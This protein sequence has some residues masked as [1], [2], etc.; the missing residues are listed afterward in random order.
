MTLSHEPTTLVVRPKYL[1]G[2]WDG[3]LGPL[4]PPPATMSSISIQMVGG[5]YV[6]VG[7]EQDEDDEW[8]VDRAVFRWEVR[9]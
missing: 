4:E 5:R 7:F 1:G 9:K 8:P 2:P 6:L 3:G